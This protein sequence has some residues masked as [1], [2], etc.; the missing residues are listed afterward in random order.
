MR[1]ISRT[2]LAQYSTHVVANGL[3][4]QAD[5]IRDVA[6][7]VAG[8]DH[9]NDFN[10]G[11]VSH[12]DTRQLGLGNRRPPVRP[13]AEFTELSRDRGDCRRRAGA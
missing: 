6:I 12:P 5:R 4:V 13:S 8:G 10:V 1:S 11:R 7:G 9:F 2:R 3:V